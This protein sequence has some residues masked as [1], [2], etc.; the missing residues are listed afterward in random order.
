MLWLAVRVVSTEGRT[1]ASRLFHFSLVYLAL[2]FVAAAF[3][4]SLAH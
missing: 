4:A 1:W 2:V 3:A